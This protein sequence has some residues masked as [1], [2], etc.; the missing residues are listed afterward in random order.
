MASKKEQIQIRFIDS[1]AKIDAKK[2]DELA[3]PLP[4]PLLE[5]HWLHQLE[6]SGSIAPETGWQPCHLTVWSENRLVGAA[7]LY[8][9]THSAGEFVFDHIWAEVA[10][11]IGVRYY[12]KLVGM[13]PVTPITGY[14]FLITDDHDQR[15]MTSLMLSTID[16]FCLEN[17]LSSANFLF[18]DPAWEAELAAAGYVD[19]HHQSFAWENNNFNDFNDFLEIFKTNQRRNIKRERQR[20][21]RQGIVI[22]SFLGDRIPSDFIDS[23]YRFYSHTNAQFGPYG[24]HYLTPEFFHGIYADF[25]RRLFFVA[26]FDKSNLKTPLAMSMLLVKANQ[27]M[28][29]YW[30]AAV[31]IKDLHFNVCYYEPIDWAIGNNIHHFDPGAGSSHKVRRGFKAV[32]N[33]SFHRFFDPKMAYLLKTHM[34]SINRLS[35]NQINELNAQSPVKKGYAC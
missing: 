35:Q 33:H 32:A 18:V 34:A 8:I 2:W 22:E 9:K 25:K 28:G 31:N 24:C 10:L 5:W 7:P 16:Q 29:R 17:D 12:P 13:S 11:Q 19:W 14:R 30:G 1:I 26:A 23:M 21:L 20:M 3:R 4:T 6:A 27:M 15:A